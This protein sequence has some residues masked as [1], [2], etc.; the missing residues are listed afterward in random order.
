VVRSLGD[1]GRSLKAASVSVGERLSKA[2]G[3]ARALR[4]ASAL[5]RIERFSAGKAQLPQKTGGRGPKTRT[6]S[7]SRLRRGACAAGFGGSA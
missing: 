7:S 5:E 6:A 2:A 1:G 4:G 3:G